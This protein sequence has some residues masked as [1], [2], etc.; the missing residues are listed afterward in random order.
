MALSVGVS[1]A[2]ALMASV[3]S[4][5]AARNGGENMA[6]AYQRRSS[7]AKSAGE[8]IENI[9]KKIMKMTAYLKESEAK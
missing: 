7:S 3:I 4:I 8:N 5:A 1:T 2:M 9:E 6:A